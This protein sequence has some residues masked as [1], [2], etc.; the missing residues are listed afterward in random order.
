MKADWHLAKKNL[1]TLAWKGPIVFSFSSHLPQTQRSIAAGELIR[2]KVFGPDLLGDTVSHCNQWN[3]SK[4]VMYLNLSIQAADTYYVKDCDVILPGKSFINKN[5]CWGWNV[6]VTYF[7]S[8]FMLFF[9]VVCF[10]FEGNLA[11]REGDVLE[12]QLG[13]FFSTPCWS[14]FFLLSPLSLSCFLVHE[15]LFNTVYSMCSCFQVWVFFFS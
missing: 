5:C 6:V 12:D 11:L 3:F 9:V 14:L 13:I 1:A 7:I 15:V 8:S 2:Y 4:Y 10:L